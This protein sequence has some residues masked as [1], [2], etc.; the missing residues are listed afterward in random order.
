MEKDLLSPEDLN[1]IIPEDNE[2]GEMDLFIDKVKKISGWG[3]KQDRIL[4]LS[5]H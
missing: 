1:K 3:L 2:E 5:T 4:M